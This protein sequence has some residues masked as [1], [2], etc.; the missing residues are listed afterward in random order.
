M[1]TRARI[2][3]R[4]TDGS[5]VSAYHHWDGYTIATANTMSFIMISVVFVA[6]LMASLISSLRA[7]SIW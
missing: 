4:Y 1:A 6:P 5:Y 2:A 3:Y 7:W